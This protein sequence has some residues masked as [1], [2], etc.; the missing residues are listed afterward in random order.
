MPIFNFDLNGESIIRSIRIAGPFITLETT[1][2]EGDCEYKHMVQL[3]FFLDNFEEVLRDEPQH[4]THHTTLHRPATWNDPL[5]WIRGMDTG[6]HVHLRYEPGGTETNVTPKAMH[7][8]LSM[9]GDLQTLAFRTSNLPMLHDESLQ[10]NN[11]PD[12]VFYDE[13]ITSFESDQVPC[14]LLE[15]SIKDMDREM[16]RAWNNQDEQTNP[17]SQSAFFHS[18]SE[19]ALTI[20]EQTQPSAAHGPLLLLTMLSSG[21]YLFWG[22]IAQLFIPADS[23]QDRAPECRDTSP[24]L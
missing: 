20:S 22:S 7:E 19:E 15:G 2:E 21:L 13:F 18:Y 4:T 6:S 17:C 8:L 16:Q 11:R 5:S 23:E 24:R 3:I 1:S 10:K 9:I 14:Y 12:K